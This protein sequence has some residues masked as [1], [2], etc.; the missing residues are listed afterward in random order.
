MSI[1]TDSENMGLDGFVWF[2][3]VV[4]DRNDPLKAGRVRVRV[5]N[6]HTEDRVQIPTS[7]LPWAQ[8][9]TP[10]TNAAMGDVGQSP[11]GA[12]EGTMVF[13]FF[14]DGKNAQHPMI[15]GSIAGIPTQ[16][17]T[18]LKDKGF[19]D[20]SGAY[21][22]RIGEPDVNRLSRGDSAYTPSVYTSKE[23]DRTLDVS[24]ARDGDAWSEPTTAN[25][26]NSVYPKN[27]VYQSESGH[28]REYDDSPNNRRI[29]EYHAA[30]TFYEIDD[31]GNKTTRVVGNN[32]TIIAGNDYIK[33]AGDANITVDG[34][35]R[36]KTDKL[37]VETGE[38]T[39]K[40]S[41]ESRVLYEGEHS[42]TYDSNRHRMIGANTYYRHSTGTDHTC[43][44]D[45]P[46]TSRTDCEEVEVP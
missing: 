33:I 3:G 1:R 45:P 10:I 30:G 16:L 32:Y 20:P 13:G 14:L 41:G 23:E 35:L 37:F 11:T 31:Q 7:S 22:N 46:R 9:V 19:S 28:I 24:T 12:V 25:T 15:L 2:F 43:P 34:T 5:Y 18:L 4:E 6:W 21:P 27:H 8:C 29:H 40:V 17:G 26:L 42:T 36:L 44:T 38:Y 39:L